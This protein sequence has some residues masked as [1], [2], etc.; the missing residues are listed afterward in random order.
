MIV[1]GL[2]AAGLPAGLVR[3]QDALIARILRAQA[4]RWE[5][6]QPKPIAASETVVLGTR[7][8]APDADSPRARP[9]VVR[10]GAEGYL[11]EIPKIRVRAIV[12]ELEPEVFSG[13]N[14]ARLKRFGLGQLPYSST[15]R[16]VS[17]G[18]EGMAVIAGHR[19]TSGAPLRQLHRLGPGDVIVLR[20]GAVEQRWEVVYSV[21]VSPAQVD[22][23]RSRPLTHRLALMACSP[24]FG[25]T[26][27]LIVYAS[28]VQKGE[29]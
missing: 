3:L 17:P 8:I 7:Q 9:P 24:P 19:T 5:A 13:R 25:A 28:L 23:I 1:G 4:D 6:E 11:L 21:T 18:E 29:D 27:R 20:K 26:A 2:T 10:S 12:R 15:L 16:N 14:T 22:A